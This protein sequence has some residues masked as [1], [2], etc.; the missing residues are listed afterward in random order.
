MTNVAPTSTH[1]DQFVHCM[2]RTGSPALVGSSVSRKQEPGWDSALDAQLRP[3]RLDAAPGALAFLTIAPA[4]TAV[5]RSVDAG[6]GEV[7]VH[8][9]V[10]PEHVLTADRAVMMGDWP[11][12]QRG[13]PARR[14]LERLRPEQ[15][16]YHGRDLRASALAQ[17]EHLARV[18]AWL[19]Q[20]PARPLG[21]VGCAASGREALLWGLM[22]ISRGLFGQRQWTFTTADVHP[23][24]IDDPMLP[25]VVFLSAAPGDVSRRRTVV[26][27]TQDQGAS[28]ENEY[29]ANALVYRFEFGIDVTAGHVPALP[30]PEP[31]TAPVPT[32]SAPVFVVQPPAGTGVEP[33]RG[34]DAR[35][36]V[37]AFVE[38]SSAFAL[39]RG[40]GGVETHVQRFP[41]DRA[42]VRA[43]LAHEGWGVDPVE[44]LLP[45][46]DH[47]SSLDRVLVAAFGPRIDDLDDA[48]DLVETS[49]SDR[50][51]HVLLR[52]AARNGRLSALDPAV[53]RRWMNRP[54]LAVPRAEGGLLATALRPVG[55]QLS[56]EHERMV[57]AVLLIVLIV[58]TF[59]LGVLVGAGP[60]TTVGLVAP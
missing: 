20:A 28:P 41:E 31:Q 5:A 16:G 53:A 11:D 52:I 39:G 24:D 9:V 1:I 59:L 43:A 7:I 44:E 54:A 26:D 45:E 58:T 19:L 10:A 12:W 34:A 48:R 25:E 36:V 3:Q 60:S 17:D 14:R 18:L 23:D 32:P 22:H 56:R 2:S 30:D 47:D 27:L 37:G 4:V 49:D 8:T 35:G 57:L 33:R 55:V 50:L 38:A 40:L 21:V 46:D 29:Q 15:I 42:A 51:V 13:V 6:A